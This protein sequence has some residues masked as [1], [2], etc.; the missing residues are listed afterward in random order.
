MLVTTRNAG[1]APGRLG[2]KK[3]TTHHASTRAA[4]LRE[5]PVVKRGARQ[6]GSRSTWQRQSHVRSEPAQLDAADTICAR[7]DCAINV[8]F[9]QSIDDAGAKIVAANLCARKA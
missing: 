8:Q 7:K 9:F 1:C 3:D 2:A 5:Q 4:C 6:R